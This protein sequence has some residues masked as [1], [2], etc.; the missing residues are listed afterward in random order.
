MSEVTRADVLRYRFHRHDLDR[1][2]GSVADPT[3][4]AL[5]AQ[6]VQ[7]TGTDGVGWALAN[8]GVEALDPAALVYAWTLRGAPH[9][10][11]RAAAGAVAVATAPY[12]EAD[13][14]KRIF[15]AAKS[16]KAAGIPV[17][18]ALGTVAGQMRRLAARPVVK[19]DVSSGLTAVLDE[20]FL[21]YCRP[22]DAVHPYEMTFRL[23]A[24]QAGLELEPGTSPPVLR[25]IPGLR[26]P[27][28]GHLAGEADDGHDVIRGYLRFFGPARFRDVAA[29]LDAPLKEVKARWPADAVEVAV[30]GE[31]PGRDG[32]RHLL[33]DD[34]GALAGAAD[35]PAPGDLRL[36]GSHDPY[37]QGRDRE[38]T[39]PDEA[40][41]KD[42]WRILGRPGAIVVDGEVVGTWRPRAAGS[43][44][45]V[46]IQ[47]WGP[48]SRRTRAALD[49]QAERL[50]AH[51]GVTL[52]AVAEEP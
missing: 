37:L 27:M 40:G 20:P 21:R 7:D 18:D 30:A 52:A 19:G 31:A 6:G 17:I 15:D 34:L 11:D 9:A 10:Y 50:A 49:E 35:G 24:L 12:S 32:P 46:R 39:V 16:L 1:P 25:R 5:L 36:L 26:A 47:P 33:A 44:L 3:E 43:K 23:A 13:A 42:L 2:A 48:L 29:Y 51:R 45:T 8:R 4:L 38:L 41:R 28:L 22:C 14:A